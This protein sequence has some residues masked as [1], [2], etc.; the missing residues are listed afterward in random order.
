MY[1]FSKRTF[2]YL[3]N[4]GF[5][6]SY[7]GFHYLG[8]ILENFEDIFNFTITH[9]YEKT[10]DIFRT[11][12]GAVERSIRYLFSKT[13]NMR[14]NKKKLIEMIIEYRGRKSYENKCGCSKREVC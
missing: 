4:K 11:N 14:V 1:K 13:N 5:N 7:Q 6:F 2:D 3:V 9:T 8:Y 10:A 12:Y